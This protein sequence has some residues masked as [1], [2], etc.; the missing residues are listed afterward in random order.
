LVFF[1]E[2]LL[3]NPAAK[4]FGLKFGQFG[5]KFGKNAFSPVLPFGG[6]PRF[7]KVFPKFPG[8]EPPGKSPRGVSGSCSKT[9]G[10]G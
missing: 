8:L 10:K 9:P 1:K 6:I 5:K 2:F 3:V 7:K 4:N